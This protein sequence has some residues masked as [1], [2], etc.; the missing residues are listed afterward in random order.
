MCFKKVCVL[1]GEKRMKI[2]INEF[3]LGVFKLL[4]VL[5]NLIRMLVFFN[6]FKI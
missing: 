1:E 2:L 4:N 6:L 5:F 3:V